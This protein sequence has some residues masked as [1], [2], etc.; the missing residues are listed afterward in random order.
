MNC[1]LIMNFKFFMLLE[2]AESTNKT[3]CSI[4]NSPIRKIVVKDNDKNF[5]YLHSMSQSNDINNK[6]PINSSAKTYTEKL[7]PNC[8]IFILKISN[9]SCFDYYYF[10]F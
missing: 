1:D 2:I 9:Y 3:H 10:F 4:M 8:G 6:K 5:S 7:M